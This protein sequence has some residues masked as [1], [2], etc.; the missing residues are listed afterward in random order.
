MEGALADVAGKS[1]ATTTLAAGAGGITC[2]ILAKIIEGNGD[3]FRTNNGNIPD[4][5]FYIRV[6][7]MIHVPEQPT[8]PKFCVLDVLHG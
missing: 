2:T 4:F 8:F 3:I 5:S 6:S 7:V 1:A